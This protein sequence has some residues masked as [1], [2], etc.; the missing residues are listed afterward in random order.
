MTLWESIPVQELG[1]CSKQWDIR[2]FLYWMADFQNGLKKDFQQKS[3]NK[4]L[5]Q[6]GILK[7]NFNLN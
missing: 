6:K 5:I 4:Q 1:G 2:M 3:N 7:Q